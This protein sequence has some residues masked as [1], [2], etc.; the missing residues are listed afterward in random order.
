MPENIKQPVVG[1]D[2]LKSR[3]YY[4]SL[5]ILVVF[6]HSQALAGNNAVQ[7]FSIWPDTGQTTCYDDLGNVLD[8]CPAPGEPFYGQ[9]AQNA[10]PARS[11]TKLDASGND[12]PDTA[13]SWSMV[14]DNVT[15]LIWEVK[16]ADDDIKN[17]SNPHDAD[18]TYTW[19]DTNPDSNGGDQGTCGINDTSGF[20]DALN[21]G[22]GFAGQT[23]WRLP[24]I[25]ELLT[26][27]HR[28][29]YN[30]A[31]TSAYFPMTLSPSY[32]SFWSST[33]YANEATA[34]YAV[35]L[36]YGDSGIGSKSISIHAIAVR[37][38]QVQP[39]NR[40][41]DNLDG[42]VTDIVTCLQWQRAT[43]DS[44]GDGN[45]DKM[46]WENALAYS[47][48]LSL[49]G[50]Q[51]WR[52]PD[53]NEFRSIVDF[54]RAN[55]SIDTNIF[56]DTLASPYRSS[57]THANNT[58]VAWLVDFYHGYD[59][60]TN[61]SIGYYVR[62]VRGGDDPC[63]NPRGNFA[64]SVNYWCSPYSARID[65][66]GGRYVFN[67][68]TCTY[69]LNDSSFSS[70]AKYGD[71][72]QG[73]IGNATLKSGHYLGA[74]CNDGVCTT[75]Q[76]DFWVGTPPTDGD[77]FFI[78]VYDSGS[79]AAFRD[80]FQQGGTPPSN[81]F[82]CVDFTWGTNT[83]KS[84]ILNLALSA[85]L[86][87][88]ANNNFKLSFP[89][90]G[91]TPFNVPITSVFDHSQA[92]RF[93]DDGKVVAYTGELGESIYGKDWVWSTHYGFK[94]KTKIPFIIN[95]NYTGGGNRYYLYY[96]GH[97]GYDYSVGG[98]NIDVFAAASGTAFHGDLGVG[99]VYI[100]HHNGY[101][102]HYLHLLVDDNL[103]K[104]N[105]SVTTSSILGLSGGTG[106]FPVHLH[107]EVRYKGVPIDPYGWHGV[108]ADPYNRATDIDLW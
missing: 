53:I 29:Q 35:N 64:D 36:Y 88:G 95:G 14:R 9:D 99:E 80:Y 97:P 52:L 40:F 39:E 94:N 46:N 21:N 89:L 92:Y 55:P 71:V 74:S 31:I 100:D 38:G 16:E 51:D 56:P 69:N 93:E 10:G 13:S 42:T 78:C 37:G 96:D 49:A 90:H 34:A 54:S 73:T 86:G 5:T 87:R 85:I 28:G 27:V 15:G 18:N 106:G 63:L 43:A 48:N 23:D 24:T 70:Y 11:Y 60:Y 103:I 66:T 61:K 22:S 75:E 44:T 17:Y 67:S 84:Q 3:L 108:G 12:L 104:N 25:K 62:T 4:F 98:K 57:T 45:P 102:T 58:N 20:L 91:Y 8:P 6:F 82:G 76:Q 105:T 68:N 72:Y 81:Q 65:S 79:L 26:L 101:T 77:K 32:P 2:I 1:G 50:Y 47:E 107:F 30:P 59:G 33:T 19:C 41:V 83:K 7:A